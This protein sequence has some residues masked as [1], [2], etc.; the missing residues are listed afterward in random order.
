MHTGYE[1]FF[2]KRICGILCKSKMKNL[3]PQMFKPIIQRKEESQKYLSKCHLFEEPRE[4]CKY[5]R[6]EMVDN[7]I[8]AID[9][10][11]L[12]HMFNFYFIPLERL[13]S[14][15]DLDPFIRMVLWLL[16]LNCYV[17]TFSSINVPISFLKNEHGEN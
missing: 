6:Q 10:K 4:M 3:N 11:A 15:E 13:F 9:L 7:R 8:K 2:A 1:N 16:E 17:V 5:L 12:S 14:K